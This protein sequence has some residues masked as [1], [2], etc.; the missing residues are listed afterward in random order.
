MLNAHGQ[1]SR[2][3]SVKLQTL[4]NV[5]N[6]TLYEA[7]VYMLALCL[8]VSSLYYVSSTSVLS[9][10][11][12]MASIGLN[13]LLALSVMAKLNTVKGTIGAI[14]VG[15]LGLV[16]AYYT[17]SVVVLKSLLLAIGA[18]NERPSRVFG[19]IWVANVT[20]ILFGLLTV[21]QGIDSNEVFRRSGMA[22]GFVHPNQAAL[23]GTVS[24]MALVVSSRCEE[25]NQ[26]LSFGKRL[27]VVLLLCFI[28]LTGSRTSF[29]ALILFAVSLFVCSKISAPLSKKR[30]SFI[31]SSIAPALMAFSLISAF[32]LYQSSFVQWLNNLLS[33]RIWLNWYA[34]DTFDI[35]LFG[36]VVDFQISGVHN[37]LTDNWNIS[38]TIDCTYIASLVRF[39][40]AATA[41]WLLAT[42]LTICR[43]WKNNNHSVACAAFVLALYAF[44][45][46]QLVDPLLF[47]PLLEVVGLTS[48]KARLEIEKN[49]F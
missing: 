6:I 28:W 13:L 18:K 7:S 17:S 48:E 31:M 20:V 25:H 1:G 38:T 19:A 40:I 30:V 4:S 24:I 21:A 47:F 49:S 9:S 23:L 42:C 36:Q 45:E 44:T 34:L 46:S 27:L 5:G 33:T 43:A 16:S 15:A 37:T 8:G 26:R 14:V 29:A 35:T 12:D 10:L 41:L 3:A 39:G 22:M 32:M 11:V 2:L